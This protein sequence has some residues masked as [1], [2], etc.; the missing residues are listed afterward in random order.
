METWNMEAWL[1]FCSFF[2]IDQCFGQF[3]SFYL[4]FFMWPV[5]W[6]D[7]MLISKM[8]CT[9]EVYVWP[10]KE[11]FALSKKNN[12]NF[13]FDVIRSPFFRVKWH[14]WNNKD[15]EYKKRDT[16]RQENGKKPLNLTFSLCLSREFCR[17]KMLQRLAWAS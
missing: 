14:I 2:S 4:F 10:K 12:A 3:L 11:S 16:R 6:L 8:I 17:K 13:L 9:Y 15:V 5:M 7:V 1:F